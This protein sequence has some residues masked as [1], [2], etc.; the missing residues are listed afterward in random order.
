MS[1][2]R[3][4]LPHLPQL[5]TQPSSLHFFQKLVEAERERGGQLVALNLLTDSSLALLAAHPTGHLLLE[6]IVNLQSGS[7]FTIMAASWICKHIS[8]VVASPSF[9]QFA[10]TVLQILLAHSE[11]ADFAL[12]LERC[13]VYYYQSFLSGGKL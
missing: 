9:A 12:T 5:A 8:S 2:S 13:E 11:N 1:L 3:A 7:C 6:T 10:S 4:V